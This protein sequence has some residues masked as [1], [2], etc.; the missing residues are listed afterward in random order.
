[1]ISKPLTYAQPTH[2]STGRGFNSAPSPESDSRSKL[3]KTL[4][5]A[6]VSS[7]A[8]SHTTQSVSALDGINEVLKSSALDAILSSVK[9]L[10]LAK[11]ISEQA[12]ATEVVL[13]FRKLENFWTETLIQE[14]VA[15]LQSA[16][17]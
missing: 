10:S 5:T 14:G 6:I 8:K 2:A 7:R 12:A 9:K 4:N 16:D 3:I 13:A 11:G 15:K 17:R 1:M